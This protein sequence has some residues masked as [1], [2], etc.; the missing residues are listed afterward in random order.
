[1]KSFQDLA[2]K[3]YSLSFSL[4]LRSLFIRITA[5]AVIIAIFLINM[6][7][8]D[9]SNLLSHIVGTIATT[10]LIPALFMIRPLAKI[11]N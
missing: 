4:H 3:F 2:N 1:M 5:F 9:T 6:A 10:L 8:M 11:I 7:W